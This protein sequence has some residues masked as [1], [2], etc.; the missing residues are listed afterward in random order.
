M[1][2]R[3]LLAAA[4]LAALCGAGNEDVLTRHIVLHVAAPPPGR[5]LVVTAGVAYKNKARPGAARV[6]SHAPDGRGGEEVVV[7][8][9]LKP[10][11]TTEISVSPAAP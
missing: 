11:R 10:H 1:P 7:E 9:A 4:V 2:K 3:T 8:A 6:V 5:A